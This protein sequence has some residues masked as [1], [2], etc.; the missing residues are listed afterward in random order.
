MFCHTTKNNIPDG[1]LVLGDR[2]YQNEDKVTTVHPDDD[3]IVHDL[4]SE[5]FLVTKH[6]MVD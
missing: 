2:F 4:K 1:R 6:S 5:L 3:E